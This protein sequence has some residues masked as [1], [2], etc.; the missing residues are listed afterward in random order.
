[1]KL[2]FQKLHP[3]LAA[4][5][6][7]AL[8]GQGHAQNNLTNG[9]VAYYP[10]NGNAINQTGGGY[11]GT[12]NGA[13]LTLDR[14]GT[15]SAAYNF[16]GT[17][18]YVVV[19]Q[20]LPDSQ[21]FTISAWIRPASLKYS[22]IFYEAAFFTPGRDTIL[23]THSDGSLQAVFTK[24]S[25]PGPPALL[26]SAVLA[27]G[28]WAHVVA[29]TGPSGTMIFVN[30]TPVAT[31]TNA[32]HNS[33]YHSPAYI[34]A[35]NHGA[36]IEYFFHGGID[37]VR[38]YNR[39]LSA[40]EVAQLHASEAP[41]V[42]PAIPTQPTAITASVGGS[43]TLSVTATG[44]APLTY[45]WAKDG[46]NVPGATNATL[47]FANVQPVNIGN[48][49]VVITNA[50]GSVTSSVA[51]LTIPGV[52]TGIWQ[53]LVAYYPFNGNANDASGNGYHG[54]LR[55]GVQLAANRFG[56]NANAYQWDGVNGLNKGIQVVDTILNTGQSQYTVNV[57]FKSTNPEKTSQTILNTSPHQGLALNFNYDGT[58]RLGI[59]LGGGTTWTAGVLYSTNSFTNS[60]W[61]MATVIKSGDLFTVYV[62]GRVEIAVSV[63]SSLWSQNSGLWLGSIGGAGYEVFAGTLDD[64]R[65]YNRALSPAEVAQLHASEAVPT[66][67]VVAWG[68][69]DYGQTSVPVGLSGVTAIA[70][71]GLHTVALKNDGTVVA[72]GYNSDGQTS[73]PVGLSGVTAI[74][75]GDDHTVAL[76]NDGTVVA[77]GRNVEG[78]TSVPVGLSGVTAIAVGGYHTVALKNDGTVVAWGAGGA[79]QSGDAHKGQSIVPAGLSGVTAIAGGGRHTVALKNDGTVVA[80][81][82]N[83]DGQTS[84]PVGLS[85]VTAIAG[86]GWHTVALKN[87]GT[88]VAWGLQGYGATSVPLGLSGVTAIAADVWHTVALKNDGTVVVWGDNRYGG[89]TV[90]AG[91]SGVTAIAGGGYHTVAL[92]SAPLITTQPTAITASVGGSAAFSVTA[93]GSE[94]AYQWKKDGASIPGATNATFTLLNIQP[95]RIGN[96]TVMIT[97]AA[98]SVTSSVASLSIPGVNSA[99]WQ[100]LVAYYPFDG[101]AN[102]ESGLGNHATP[103][104]N[105][106]FIGAGL[107]G[108]AIRTIGDGSQYYNGGGHVL[109]PKFDTS[110]NAGFTM[111]FWAR[112]EIKGPAPAADIEVYIDFW[113]GEW[114]DDCSACDSNHLGNST[115]RWTQCRISSRYQH[116][117]VS[118]IRLETSG[119]CLSSRQLCLL[120]Q[121]CEA[122]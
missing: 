49:T 21:S 4:L 8:A 15:P 89:T 56:I 35:Q 61:R 29:T 97:N 113:G 2:L 95:G 109:L 79:G 30:G 53:N 82:N 12:V 67:T 121:R 110:L 44:S 77:W 51:S 73:V 25:D 13:Q 88:V 32:S 99:L 60:E 11:N 81:G 9:L 108:G 23:E 91:L 10:F 85:G 107:S 26:A 40:P 43:A 39:A 7:A 69:N 14:F 74:A 105:F 66:G 63:A 93:T 59:I 41:A 102:D 34:G 68:R 101:N 64:A 18:D 36:R 55:P 90:P 114:S 3:P 52:P 118:F 96:Y 27:Q 86:G 62:D 104:G 117:A 47:T 72:W 5:L 58:K 100:G 42:A 28:L 115:T 87:D 76:K 103:A 45:Q 22:G 1:M 122:F 70:G 48:Y 83:S 111:S 98:G 106:Q 6:L 80:W 37:D 71:G 38:I 50:A 33:G 92:K 31:Q 112:D 65:I 54:I 94:L 46:V 17:S 24:K 119:T 120:S 57:W 20:N 78:Q 84:V 16:N 116:D 75:A 19:N